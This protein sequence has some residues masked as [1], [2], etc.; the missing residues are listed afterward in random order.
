VVIGKSPVLDANG[1]FTNASDTINTSQGGGKVTIG[2]NNQMFNPGNGAYFT[3]VKS[4]VANF[5]AGAPGGLDQ[6]E[7]DDADNI[8]YTGRTLTAPA[9]SATISQTQ[10]NAAASMK[11]TAFDIADSPQARDFV[12]GL[13]SGVAVTITAVKVNGVPVSFTPSGNGVIVSNLHAGDK[14]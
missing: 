9:A 2:V 7:A 4:P 5:L 6:N 10:G 1:E 3:Y 14:I 12:S 8:Q 11:I 13:G